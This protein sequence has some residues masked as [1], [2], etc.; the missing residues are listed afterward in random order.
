MIIFNNIYK[1]FYWLLLFLAIIFFYISKT[2]PN[3]L[4]A[5]VIIILISYYLYMYLNNLSEKKEIDINK[6]EISIMKDIADRKEMYTENYY[7]K[8]FPKNIKYLFNDDNLMNIITNIRFVKKFDKAKYTD[9]ILYTEKLMKIYIYILS[10]RYDAETYIQNFMDIRYSILEIFYSL[11]IVVPDKL[12]HAYG[13]DT[14]KEINKSTNDFLIYSRKM[15]KTLENYAK[16]EKGIKY[17]QDNKY[18]AYNT[19]NKHIMP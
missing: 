13:L 12:N 8:I 6:N 17:I 7:V 18:R 19:L 5:I 15:L 11:I 9:I 10:D 14:Y 1:E 16:I 3:I 4:L 2:N